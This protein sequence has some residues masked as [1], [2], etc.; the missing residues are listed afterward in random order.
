MWEYRRT[1]SRYG[2]TFARLFLLPQETKKGFNE[3]SYFQDFFCFER[4][5][6]GERQLWTTGQ[7]MSFNEYEK[8]ARGTAM[9]PK[10]TLS[11]I[12]YLALGL[13]GEA[14]E[15]AEKVKK[16]IRDTDD[17]QEAL[18]EKKM[19][20]ALELGD[21]LWYVSQLCSEIGISMEEVAEMNINKLKSRKSRK[22]ITGSG[23]FR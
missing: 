3:K 11:S 19:D 22:K 18:V 7:G 21:V 20:L 2:R 23:D 8:I 17:I 9:Y 10:D 12:S 5:S 14:G 15:V 1:S 6:L 13:N 16:M 4:E